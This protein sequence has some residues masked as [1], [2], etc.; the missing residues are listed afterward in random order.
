LSPRSRLF[1]YTT[2]FRSYPAQHAVNV[3][4]GIM[5]GPGPAVG[6]AFVIGLL[7]NLLGIG[8]LLAFPGGMVGAFM[9]GY[10][11]KKFKKHHWE[12]IGDRKSTRLNSSHVSIS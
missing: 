8:S 1:P 5:L 2:L 11:Y 10:F 6:I 4:A 12:A 9:A 7:R 3:M